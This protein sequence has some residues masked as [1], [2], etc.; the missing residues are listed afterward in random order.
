MKCYRKILR[1]S[2]TERKTKA[3]VLEQLG[4]K[5]PQLLNLIKKQK[6][7]YFGHIKRH[8]TLEKLFLEGTCEGGEAE[9]DPGDGRRTLANGWESRLWRLEDKYLREGSSVRQFGRP[10]PLKIRHRR[11]RRR[12]TESD[13]KCST[14]SDSD[15]TEPKARSSP[16]PRSSQSVDLGGCGPGP[17][18]DS[19][20]VQTDNNAD[21]DLEWTENYTLLNSYFDGRHC[22]PRN[23]LPNINEE[24][25]PK[26]FIGLFLDTEFWENLTAMTNLL[27]TQAKEETPKYY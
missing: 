19:T 22:G 1:I 11:R 21:L 3:S 12:R 14:D 20:T 18:G 9:G 7:S 10:R 16:R 8:N 17:S 26:D 6:L 4:V 24:S 23:V 15:V 2:W 27:S 13:I 25:T 5:A